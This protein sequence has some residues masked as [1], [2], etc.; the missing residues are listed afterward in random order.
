MFIRNRAFLPTCYH[1][2]TIGGNQ[3]RRSVVDSRFKNLFSARACLTVVDKWQNHHDPFFETRPSFSALLLITHQRSQEAI[4]LME[5]DASN[6]FFNGVYS[7]VTRWNLSALK[8]KIA[9]YKLW[10]DFKSKSESG[11]EVPSVLSSY[12]ENAPIKFI[13]SIHSIIE[14]NGGLHLAKLSQGDLRFVWNNFKYLKAYDAMVEMFNY[15]RPSHFTA[16]NS[17]LCH[18]A[19]ALLNSS[20]GQPRISLEFAKR[21]ALE[22]NRMEIHH[23]IQGLSYQ[24]CGRVAREVAKM[25]GVKRMDSKMVELY[26]DCFPSASIND[27]HELYMSSFREAEAEFEKAFFNEPN[28]IHG[29]GYILHLV[30]QNKMKDASKWSSLVWEQLS[31]LDEFTPYQAKVFVITGILAK[32]T[33]Q[34]IATRLMNLEESKKMTRVEILEILKKSKEILVEHQMGEISAFEEIV[35]SIQE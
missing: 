29:L 25:V 1:F 3:L 14:N 27:S 33:P 32:K 5:E 31:I 12:R 34:L 8:R 17:L 13:D 15:C 16:S 19:F 9:P 26:K 24:L 22:E 35:E 28:A 10:N 6:K 11:L 2:L 23:Y 30:D 21:L 7:K 18:Y 20:Y 4:G